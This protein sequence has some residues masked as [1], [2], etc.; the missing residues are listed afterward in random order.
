MN[1]FQF[2]EMLP[3]GKDETPYRL[4]TKDHVSTFEAGGRTFLQVAPEALTLLTR[5]AMRDIAHLLR[6]GHL[7]QLSKILQDPEASANDRFVALELLKNANIAAGG[8]LPSCQDTGTAIIMGKKGQHVLTDGHDE[9]ALSRGVFETYRTSNLRYSQMAALDMYK[10]AN[11]GNNLPAQIELYATGGDAYKFL[12]MAKGGGS[13]NKSYLFQETKALLNPTSLLAFLDAKIRSLG[14]A[15]CPPYHLAIVVG[16][17][18]AEFALKTAKYA[19]ARYLDTL[20]TE[21]NA[22]GRGFRDVALEQEVLKL[23][24]RMGIGAQFGGK[25]FCHDVRVIRLPR[26]GASCPVA[27]AVSC[28]ADRQV[29]GKIT[30]DGVFLEQLEADPA[31]Y[32][33]ETTDADLAGEVVK[34]DLNRPMSELRAEL[35]RYPIKTRV[36]LTGPMVVAR[37]IAHAKLKERLDRGEGMP[38]YLKDRMVYYAGPAKTPEG[39]ASGSFGPTTAGRMDAYVDQF[40]AEGGSFVMLAKGN[41]SQAVTDACKKHGGFYLGS[42]GGPA[43]RLAKDCITKVEVLEYEELGMEAVWKIEV[44]DF[45]AFIVVDDKGNDFFA[46][47]NKPSAKKG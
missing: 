4:L 39:Y 43:A 17:T 14:T 25:Y 16:G 19:S 29:L 37:D 44:V 33:P 12:F 3:L 6:P 15:A 28:S 13:A 47:L 35:S 41:R 2:Q 18:S 1:D 9:E 10:E 22:L 36:S 45:P 30:R 8:V 38:Q 42:I 7:G 24:Q 32:L 23:T 11:T 46:H 40:Q 21:G 5:E 27:I 34:L 31:K 26:H 20:P